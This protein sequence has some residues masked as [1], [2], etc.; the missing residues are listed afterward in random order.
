MGDRWGIKREILLVLS[1]EKAWD[2]LWEIW[3]ACSLDFGKEK[4]LGDWSV[5]MVVGWMP[6]EIESLL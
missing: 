6:K 1:M 4:T 2:S 3:M 5:E